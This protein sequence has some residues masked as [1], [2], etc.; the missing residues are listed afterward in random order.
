MA[1]GSASGVAALLRLPDAETIDDAMEPVAAKKPPGKSDSSKVLDIRR[2][3]PDIVFG[4]EG[5]TIG[6]LDCWGD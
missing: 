1:L 5:L 2:S 3:V 4:V 6:A